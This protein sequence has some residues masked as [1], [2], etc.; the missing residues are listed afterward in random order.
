MKTSAEIAQIVMD[1]RAR[2]NP[3]VF[4]GDLL[5]EIGPEGMSEAISRRWLV[6]DADSGFLQV[7]NEDAKVR[8]MQDAIAE[9]ATKTEKGDNEKGCSC[10]EAHEISRK[11]ADRDR[12]VSEATLGLGPS[13]PSGPLGSGTSNGT[14]VPRPSTASSSPLADRAKA[15]GIGDDVTVVEDGKVYQG[16]VQAKT[17]EGKYKVS[18]GGGSKPPQERDYE[19]TELGNEADRK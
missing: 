6:P 15:K 2:M 19:E 10:T 3:T 17:K 16:K 18:F 12:S 8:E 4:Q 9:E 7:T 5:P 11:H 1:R 13:R 14:P